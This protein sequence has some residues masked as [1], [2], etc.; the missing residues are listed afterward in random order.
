V[1]DPAEGEF[2]PLLWQQW[3]PFELFTDAGGLLRVEGEQTWQVRLEKVSGSEKESF[4]VLGWRSRVA[5]SAGD[6]W[7]GAALFTPDV[8]LEHLVDL[9]RPEHASF[10]KADSPP[11]PLPGLQGIRGRLD[12]GAWRYA[13]LWEDAVAF[14]GDGQRLSIDVGIGSIELQVRI[15]GLVARRRPIEKD[16]ST[17]YVVLDPPEQPFEASSWERDALLPPITFTLDFLKLAFRNTSFAIDDG[18]WHHNPIPIPVVF[19]RIGRGQP[20]PNVQ[21]VPT[22]VT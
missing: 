1:S 15:K 22:V 21:F 9:A 3:E 4:D 5:D 19:R 17:P 11:E 2:V 6:L 8:F 20:S 18:F 14:Q 10:E 16:E 7:E 12:D 13:L